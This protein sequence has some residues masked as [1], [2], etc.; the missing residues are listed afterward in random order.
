MCLR[1]KGIEEEDVFGVTAADQIIC[2]QTD[3]IKS[4]DDDSNY[5][6]EITRDVKRA[7][8]CLRLYD[9]EKYGQPSVR[10]QL[11]VLNAEVVNI[12]SAVRVCVA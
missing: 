2:I 6:V 3:G 5:V 4:G 10:L 1:A 8:A 7:W 12:M 11:R 9:R